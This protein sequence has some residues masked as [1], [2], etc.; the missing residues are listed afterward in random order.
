M[1]YLRT[2]VCAARTTGEYPRS[3]KMDAA[4]RHDGEVWRDI[5]SFVLRP[6][7]SAFSL[8]LQSFQAGT[9]PR[10]DFPFGRTTGDGPAED[11]TEANVTMVVKISLPPL[12]PDRLAHHPGAQG[13]LRLRD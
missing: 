9:T 5:P 1:A 10:M 13:T 2:M 11:A 4:R 7:L 8:L 12:G 6:Q 3:I